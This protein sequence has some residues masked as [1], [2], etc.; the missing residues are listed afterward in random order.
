MVSSSK[1]TKLQGKYDYDKQPEII[2]VDGKLYRAHFGCGDKDR[3]HQDAAMRSKNTFVLKTN[4]Y[5]V[6]EL[7]TRTM[8]E[9]DYLGKEAKD[10]NPKAAA[11]AKNAISRIRKSVTKA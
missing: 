11:A 5:W 8:K 7:D 6:Y 3:A 4:A 9:V 2:E 10:S 1:V